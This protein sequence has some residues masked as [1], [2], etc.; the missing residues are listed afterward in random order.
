MG[1]P[2]GVGPLEVALLEAEL[3]GGI[4]GQ[5]GAREDFTPTD[6]PAE[7]KLRGPLALQ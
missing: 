3:V 7:L 1:V 5:V 4:L 2:G 6:N